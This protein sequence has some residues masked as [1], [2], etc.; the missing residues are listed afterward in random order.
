LFAI[1]QE[2]REALAKREAEAD[3]CARHWAKETEDRKCEAQRQAEA[4]KKT[5]GREL[6][7]VWERQLE[8]KRIRQQ[9]ELDPGNRG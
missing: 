6:R 1:L 2:I 7:L 8:D 5:A 9:S 4:S 3:E